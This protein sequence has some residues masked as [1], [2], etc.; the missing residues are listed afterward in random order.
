[1]AEMTTPVAHAPTW[2]DEETLRAVRPE[3]RS[4]LE[5][6]SGFAHLTPDEQRELARTMVKVCAYMSN[7]D[8]LAARELS[9]DGGILARAQDD[10]TDATKKRL[11]EKQGFAGKDFQAGAIKAGVKQFGELVK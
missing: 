3:V 7:P 2:L 11:S 8:G 5:A 9:N 10:A 6:S 1:M 4:V